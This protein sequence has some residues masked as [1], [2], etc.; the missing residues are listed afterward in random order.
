MS[1]EQRAAIFQ[2][3]GMA[4]M[5]W[6]KT[7]CGVFDSDRAEMIGNTL[8]EFLEHGTIPDWYQDHE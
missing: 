3:L 5:C 4:S 7:P 2:A 6:S 8:V 1:D